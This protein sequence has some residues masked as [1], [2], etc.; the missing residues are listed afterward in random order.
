M[1]ELFYQFILYNFQ[2]FGIIKFSHPLSIKKLA[3]TGLDLPEVG[4]TPADGDKE[5]LAQNVAEILTDKGEMLKEYFSV[6]I[7]KEGN[8]NALPLILGKKCY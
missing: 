5:H 4:W 2:N 7:D 3:L 6:D 1:Q 8:L